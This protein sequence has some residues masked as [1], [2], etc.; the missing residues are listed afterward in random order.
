[1]SRLAR[2]VKDTLSIGDRLDSAGADLVSL[3]ESTDTTSAAGKM[4]FRMLAVLSEFERDLN[5][6]VGSHLRERKCGMIADMRKATCVTPVTPAIALGLLL[7]LSATGHTGSAPAEEPAPIRLIVRGDDMGSTEASNEAAIRCFRE[8]VM[9]TVEV[10]A[11]GPWFPDAVRR[12][13]E[14]PRLDVGLHLTLTSEWDSMKWRPIAAVPSLVDADGYFFPMVWPG[15]DYGPDRALKSQ[16]W[17]LDEI[18]RELQA[19]IDLA[20]RHLPQ[21]SHLSDHMGLASLGPEVEALLKRLADE[22]GLDIDPEALGVKHLGWG[23]PADTAEEKIARL[24][25]TLETLGPGTW[26]FVDHPAFDTPEMRS[27]HHQGYETVAADRQGVAVAWTSAPV[28]EAVRARRIQLVS[29]RDL[30]KK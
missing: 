18:E 23:G 24:A 21:L 12:L 5:L 19:Q 16:P 13:R 10:M 27:I 25:R 22:S 15:P 7:G 3:S 11:V 2:S 29:Y 1:M 30:K 4:V 8:G 28:L 20:K 14:N 17:K 9:R 26:L 6:V